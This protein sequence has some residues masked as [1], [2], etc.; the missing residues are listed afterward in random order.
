MDEPAI[1]SLKFVDRQKMHGALRRLAKASLLVGVL[2]AGMTGCAFYNAF[3]DPPEDTSDAFA[4]DVSFVEDVDAIDPGEE[5]CTAQSAGFCEG[6][7]CAR[8]LRIAAGADFACV[9]L[10]NGRVA[11]W[12][13][14]D[15]GQVTGS[16][17]TALFRCPT[18]SETEDVEALSTGWSHTCALLNSGELACWGDDSRG[19]GS[20]PG[21]IEADSLAAG[22]NHTCALVDGTVTC[23]GCR[24]DACSGRSS[25]SITPADVQVEE[26][27]A[28][29]DANCHTA[30]AFTQCTGELSLNTLG[31]SGAEGLEG[32]ENLTLGLHLACGIRTQDQRAV[33]WGRNNPGRGDG[34]GSN[35]IP[36]D[37]PTPFLTGPRFQR[38]AAG[39]GTHICGLDRDR[40]VHCWGK[41]DSGQ[42]GADPSDD[43]F[44]RL[45][46]EVDAEALTFEDVAV[47]ES[48]SCALDTRGEIWCWGSNAS[49]VLGESSITGSHAPVRVLGNRGQ[50]H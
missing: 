14:N 5:G 8:P 37:R 39:A 46:R 32:V 6:G 1:M 34:I 35:L 17:S 3:Q 38:L 36:E 49:G 27:A 16:N 13:A 20:P 48:F 9:L 24:S 23:W 28:G 11:C 29:W 7:V 33:C 15:L 41:N 47:G 50:N 10:S 31:D 22:A 43:V 21:D 45:P 12:G 4:E 42:I 44:L 18:L 30:Q 26:I 40:K 25:A 19:Q 2:V